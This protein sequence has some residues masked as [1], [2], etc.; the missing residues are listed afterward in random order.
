MADT[1][2]ITLSDTAWTEVAGA[3]TSGYMTNEG[4]NKIKYREAIFFKIIVSF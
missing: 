2:Q 4:I 3:A 1:V